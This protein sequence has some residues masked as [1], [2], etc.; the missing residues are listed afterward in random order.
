ML[1]RKCKVSE[2]FHWCKHWELFICVQNERQNC[3]R[4]FL[5]NAKKDMTQSL[6]DNCGLCTLHKLFTTHIQIMTLHFIEIIIKFKVSTIC[7]RNKYSNGSDCFRN[8]HFGH[9]KSFSFWTIIT[10]NIS[11]KNSQDIKNSQ[12]M[13]I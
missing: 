11:H 6:A 4:L 13:Q 2:N 5:R 7:H 8:Y 3:E 1:N 9:V 12:K 10:N